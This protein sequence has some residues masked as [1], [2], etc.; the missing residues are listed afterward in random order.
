M[1]LDEDIFFRYQAEKWAI[2]MGR[3]SNGNSLNSTYCFMSEV[4]GYDLANF[5]EKHADILRD[6]IAR[7]LEA[8]LR[9]E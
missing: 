4:I 7:V 3:I 6:E 9:P 8:L 5:F 1:Q 2:L